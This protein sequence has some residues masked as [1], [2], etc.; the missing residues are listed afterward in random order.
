MATPGSRGTLRS[1]ERREQIISL[2]TDAGLASVEELAA[3]FGVTASTIRRDLTQLSASGRL[4]RTYGGAIA[5]PHRGEASLDQ[6]DSE[7]FEPKRAIARWAADRVEVGQSLLLDAGTT[8]ALVARALPPE[9]SLTVTTASLPVLHH[10][11]HRDDITTLCLGGRLR[12]LSDAFVGP[13]AEAALERMSFDVAFLGADGVTSDGGL[14]EAEL[15]QTRLKELMARRSRRV[16]VL[17]HAAK[18]GH[19]PF[20]AWARLETDWTLVT[21]DGAP[22]HV[23]EEFRAAG[24]DVVVVPTARHAETAAPA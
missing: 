6:R 23:L 10:V 2:A 11:Q 14:C 21:D 7:A 8:V 18:L 4:A 20:R 24:R 22:P 13:L 3:R 5:V 19:R 16:Y 1:R 9:A 17:T 12:A 15:E